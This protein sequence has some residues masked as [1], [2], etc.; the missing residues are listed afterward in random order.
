MVQTGSETRGQAGSDLTRAGDTCICNQ[1]VS[2]GPGG[3]V[4]PYLFSSQKKVEKI[5][6]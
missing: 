1:C 6:V 3:G 4:L 5:P 2:T